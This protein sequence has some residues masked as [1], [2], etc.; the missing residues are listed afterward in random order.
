MAGSAAPET[1]CFFRQ[2][3]EQW[4]GLAKQTELLEREQ[5]YRIVSNRS[6]INRPVQTARLIQRHSESK[7]RHASVGDDG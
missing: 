1:A 2:V 7:A 4:R 5:E 6:K 3:A